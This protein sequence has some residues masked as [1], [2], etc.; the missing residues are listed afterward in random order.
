[1]AIARVVIATTAVRADRARQAEAV[2][3]R[4]AEI[5]A[6]REGIVR[7]EIVPAGRVPADHGRAGIAGAGTVRRA[8]VRRSVAMNRAPCARPHRRS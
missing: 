1:M 7:R 8:G 4:R 3:L 5:V 2:R 6:D